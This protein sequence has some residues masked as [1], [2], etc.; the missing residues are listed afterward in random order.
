M[1]FKKLSVGSSSYGEENFSEVRNHLTAF[2][3]EQSATDPL[4]R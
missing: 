4:S 2:F 3:S 1:V